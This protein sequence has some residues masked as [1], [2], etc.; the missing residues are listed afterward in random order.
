M[1]GANGDVRSH[2]HNNL[3]NKQSE[4]KTLDVARLKSFIEN[5]K[6]NRGCDIESDLGIMTPDTSPES[7]P[8]EKIYHC[9]NLIN[10]DN[11][12]TLSNIVYEF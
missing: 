9:P 5:N 10:Q 3:V 2:S 1:Y 7:S 11:V 12:S 6:K 4:Y 8:N